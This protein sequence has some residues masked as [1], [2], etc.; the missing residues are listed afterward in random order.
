MTVEYRPPRNEAELEDAFAC[1]ARAFG[2]GLSF[3]TNIVKYDPWFCLDNARA[4]FVDGKVVSLVQ[5]FERP[6]RIGNCV[7]RMGGVGSV[8]TDPAYRR[9]GH[10]MNVLRDSV[11]YMKAE[12]YDLSILFTGIPS[13]YGKAGWVVHPV[14]SVRLTLPEALRE[15]QTEC[16]IE[17]CD[18]AR[19][20]PDLMAIYDAFNAARTGTTVRTEIYWN[21]QPKWREYDPAM[22]WVAKRNSRTVAYLKAGRWSLNEL[23]Y[24]NGEE[25]A[26]MA[27]CVYFFRQAQ[28]EAVKEVESRCPLACCEMFEAL[29]CAVRRRE[30]G[31]TMVQVID[32]KSLL[33]KV[34]PLLEARLHASGFSAWTGAICVRY[35]ADERMLSIQN[36]KITVSPGGVSPNI[37]LVVSQAQ[38]LRLLFGSMRAEDIAFSNRLALRED[39]IGLL[40]A[41]FPPDELFLWGTDGF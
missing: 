41:L 10:S 11:E 15:V 39:E 21:Q 2:G 40:N 22:F 26:A 5:I 37:D 34:T 17:L 33:A 18:L 32:L 35:E 14:Y 24:V 20:L 29:G 25:A 31:G 7:V 1:T 4:C 19:D 27:L 3:F 23:G 12:G 9:A 36:G 16:Q 38:L 13:H 30:G 6:M 8:G 28:A